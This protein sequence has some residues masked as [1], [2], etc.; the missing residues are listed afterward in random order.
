M[1]AEVF[2]ERHG[3][4][5]QLEV[6]FGAA[7]I[8]TRGGWGGDAVL[9]ACCKMVCRPRGT[10]QRRGRVVLVD[11]HRTTRVSSAV[12]GQ[13]PCERQL[14]KRRATRPADW[15]PPARQVEPR[16][17]RPAWSQQRDQPVRG[18]M[19]CPVVAPRKP[20]QAPRS[21]QEATSA[22]ASEPRPSTP[23]P[24]KR[25]KPTKA[26]KAKPAPQPGRWLDRDC[27]AA[28]NMQRIG[29]ASGD[30][31]SCAGI[32]APIQAPLN[33]RPIVILPGFGNCTQDYEA[34]FGQSSDS[35]AANLRSRGWAVHVVRLERSDWFQV[36][37][38]LFTLKFWS[39][40][41]S[42]EPGYT[43][44]LDRV[45]EAVQL[46]LQASGAQQVDLVGHSAGGWLARA[47]IGD[48][49]YQGE[50]AA[51]ATAQP[52]PNPAVRALV[53]LG[54]PQ[55]PP[56]PELARDMTGG[57]LAWVHDRYPGAFFADQG[58]AYVT[59]AGL[60]VK[61]GRQLDAQGRPVQVK[62]RPRLPS[63][64]A[65]DSYGQVCGLGQGV[66]GDAV[67][68]LN[69][70]CLQGARQVLLPG[71]W[72]SVSKI[73]TFDEASGVV[74]YGSGAVVDAW[75]QP[76]VQEA[77]PQAGAAVDRVDKMSATGV[78]SSVSS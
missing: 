14:N 54:S 69:S 30:H 6:F 71:V 28:L 25:S 50:P 16:L 42:T 27:N 37:R 58:V 23:L 55:K 44:Y 4:A 39:S 57:A 1:V 72:H 60:T 48:P 33:A 17:V 7:G 43:W 32:A 24:A 64:Y 46:A 36:A 68:P 53:T 26:A 12:N 49:R 73:G 62:G 70:A 34:P 8:G 47:Y 38:A 61:G 10:D 5:K 56:P 66:E 41:L 11:E 19:W 74:W 77:Y 13:Q 35:L 18:L 22:A 45:Q 29:G 65:Y 15:K 59:V 76:Y 67:V 51:S 63:E 9:R 2:M 75:L 78:G 3:H 52:C 21:S 31:W 20:P 40:Q